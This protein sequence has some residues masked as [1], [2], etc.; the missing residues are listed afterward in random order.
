ME[1]NWVCMDWTL[2]EIPQHPE[3]QRVY[4]IRLDREAELLQTDKQGGQVYGVHLD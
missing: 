1:K 4:Y 3:A 2:L